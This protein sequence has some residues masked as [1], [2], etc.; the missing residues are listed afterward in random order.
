MLIYVHLNNV[1][2]FKLYVFDMPSL[3]VN[4]HIDVYAIVEGM[5]PKDCN[6]LR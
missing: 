5:L 3:S 6:I 4:R 2:S 1:F